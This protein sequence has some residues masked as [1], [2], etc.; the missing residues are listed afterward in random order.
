MTEPQE[1]CVLSRIWLFE[2][3]WTVD[4]QTPLSMEF[5]RQELEWSPILPPEDLL[6]PEIKLSSPV[7]SA[8]EADSLLAEPLRKL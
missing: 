1:C 5:S 4:F 2:T 6:D 7:S 3:L 8:L